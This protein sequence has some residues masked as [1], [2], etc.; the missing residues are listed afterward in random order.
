VLILQL[1]PY[2]VLV[3]GKGYVVASIVP[4]EV[5]KFERVIC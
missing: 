1:V 4:N 5:L 2:T 3:H